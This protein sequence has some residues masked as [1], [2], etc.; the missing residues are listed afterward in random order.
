MPNFVVADFVDCGNLS[1][2]IDDMNAI[3]N[4]NGKFLPELFAVL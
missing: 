3:I 2:I 1:Q 4:T